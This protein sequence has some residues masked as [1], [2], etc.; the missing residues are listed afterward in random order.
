MRCAPAVREF[1]VAEA[2]EKRRGKFSRDS[3]PVCRDA[4]VALEEL[5]YL[6]PP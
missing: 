3:L 4:N 5:M 6:R 2:E 1:I